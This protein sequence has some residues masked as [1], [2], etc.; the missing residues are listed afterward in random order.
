VIAHCRRERAQRA[1][2]H[3]VEVATSLQDQIGGE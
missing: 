1:R 3:A 2:P